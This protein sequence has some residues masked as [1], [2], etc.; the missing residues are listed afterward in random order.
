MNIIDEIKQARKS[1]LTEEQKN[2]ILK[3]VKNGLADREFF[4]IQGAPH[5]G[6]W[7]YFRGL[8]SQAPYK[9]H[10]AIT[11]FLRS[12]GFRVS[13]YYNNFG[14]EYGMKIEL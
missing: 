1:Q 12:Q 5:F 11:D 4:V 9:L 13:R 14:V 7:E 2:D 3:A 8:V 10:P 6:K